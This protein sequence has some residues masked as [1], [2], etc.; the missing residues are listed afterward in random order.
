MAKEKLEN[1][2]DLSEEEKARLSA[3]T[4]ID[5]DDPN[6]TCTA[7]GW[8]KWIA[9]RDAEKARYLAEQRNAKREK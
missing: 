9:H 8:K 1:W 3:K 7:E 2:K 6:Y 5:K 4:P